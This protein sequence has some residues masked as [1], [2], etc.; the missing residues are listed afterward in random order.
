M[1]DSENGF[2]NNFE[3]IT[4]FSDCNSAEQKEYVDEMESN[5]KRLLEDNTSKLK[6]IPFPK[7]IID[8]LL[9]YRC[10]DIDYKVDEKQFGSGV[11]RLKKNVFIKIPDTIKLLDYQREAIINW[12]SRALQEYMIWQQVQERL[13]RHWE[14]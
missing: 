10:G 7:I 2:E 4:V 5:F 8:K 13:L 1:N 9:A 11:N 3:L 12:K 6:V 14:A